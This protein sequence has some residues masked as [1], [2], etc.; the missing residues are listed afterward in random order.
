MI[1]RADKKGSMTLRV[2][3]YFDL[4]VCGVSARFMMAYTLN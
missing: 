2:I 4:A 1:I 3:D